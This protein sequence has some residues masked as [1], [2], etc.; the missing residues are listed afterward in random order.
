MPFLADY[1]IWQ[2]L[3][4]NIEQFFATR[5]KS[6]R[7]Q[8]HIEMNGMNFSLITKGGHLLNGSIC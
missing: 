2:K 5:S 8:L 7:K 4:Q 6:P 1:G 3:L